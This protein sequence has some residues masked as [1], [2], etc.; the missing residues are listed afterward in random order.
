MLINIHS[1]VTI[2]TSK[3]N[4][5]GNNMDPSKD[6]SNQ[7]LVDPRGDWSRDEIINAMHEAGWS[8]RQLSLQHGLFE[9]TYGKVLWHPYPKV[10]KM[11][12]EIIGVEPRIIWPSRYGSD[13]K[14][15]R[16]VGRKVLNPKAEKVCAEEAK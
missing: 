15:N 10:E 6:P 9:G 1:Y 2:H 14:P 16:K 13:G 11:V 4:I 12:G 5:E 7:I 3:V 8:L